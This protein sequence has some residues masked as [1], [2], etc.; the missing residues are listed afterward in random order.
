MNE[1][2]NRYTKFIIVYIDDVL[3]YSTSLEQ[4]FKHLQIFL[5]LIVRNSLV[6]SRTKMELFQTKIRFLGHDLVQGM[7]K[8]IKRSMEFANKFPNVILEKR[9]LLRFLRSLK[10]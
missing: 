9:Q 5:G 1:I 10:P 6:L 7:L 8:P 3:V 4:H 2:F